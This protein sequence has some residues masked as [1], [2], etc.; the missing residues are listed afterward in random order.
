MAKFIGPIK[1]KGSAGGLTG[2]YDKDTG[3]FHLASKKPKN[4][5]QNKD[6]PRAL[7]QNNEFKAVCIWSSLIRLLTEEFVY[8]KKGRLAGKLNAIAKQ[9][10]LM[11][12]GGRYGYR[13]IESSKFNYPLNGF[14]FNNAHPFKNVFQ[15]IPDV[16]ITDD[17]SQVTLKLSDFRSASKFKWPDAV[18]YYRISLLIIVLPD[19]V[20]NKT[21]G[22]YTYVNWPAPLGQKLSVSE[23]MS[24]NNVPIDFEISAAFKEGHLPG[25]KST[26]VVLMGL[27]FATAMQNNSPYVVKGIGT[28]AVVACL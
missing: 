9:I 27:E 16:S 2:F 17:R 10:Q 5:N 3:E 7:D 20:W 1:F 26:V 13:T 22:R 23:W 14:S 19:V 4:K 28:A 15:V 11:D 18:N 8:L 12:T 21:E 24:V 25:A 6:S